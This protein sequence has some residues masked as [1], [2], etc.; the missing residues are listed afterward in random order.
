MVSVTPASFVAAP[1][2]EHDAQRALATLWGVSLGAGEP[3]EQARLQALQCFRSNSMTL[4]TLRQ[5][6]RPGVITLGADKAGI[7]AALLV[8]LGQYSAIVR[9]GGQN[10]TLSLAT[11][12]RAWRGDFMSYWRADSANAS[13]SWLA[14]QLQ[15]VDA[16]DGSLPLTKRIQIFQRSQGL[17]ADGVAG[18]LTLMQLNRALGIDE[19]RLSEG[20]TP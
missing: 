13:E 7:T 1:V 11:L 18:A 10:Q 16:A 4:A 8:G 3:C 12:G 15:Q 19:P 6:A 2:S 14:Q 20:L 9:V 17:G 5:L